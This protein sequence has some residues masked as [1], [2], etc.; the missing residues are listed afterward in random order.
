MLSLGYNRT[1]TLIVALATLTS[2]IL[3]SVLFSQL[4]DDPYH[5]AVNFRWYLHF[6]NVL[7]VFGFLGALR[8]RSPPSQ[9]LPNPCLNPQYHKIPRENADMTFLIAAT[10][11]LHS[12]LLQ[13]PPPRHYPLRRPTFPAPWPPAPPLF[14]P[15]LRPLIPIHLL[16]ILEPTTY[17][18]PKSKSSNNAGF[19]MG[20]IDGGMDAPRL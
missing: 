1:V 3:S 10:C 18:P 8:V 12:H 17:H 15:L 19:A 20:G 4:P 5:L 9:S 16:P 7:S 2:N 14:H 6:A 11:T 13:L